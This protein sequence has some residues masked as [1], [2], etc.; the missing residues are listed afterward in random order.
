MF[1]GVLTSLGACIDQIS[2]ELEKLNISDWELTS[3]QATRCSLVATRVRVST[4]DTSHH[5]SWSSIDSLIEQSKI[6]SFAS[7]GARRSFRLLAEAEAAIH[8]V[9]VDDVHFHEVGA[10]D[11]IVDIVGSWVALASLVAKQQVKE[12]ITGPVGLGHGIV[13][14][15]HGTLPLPAPATASLLHGALVQPLDAAGES[16]TPT[17]A[18]LLASMTDRWGPIPSGVLLRNGRG[19]GG[20]DPKH[21][22]N[23]ISGYLLAIEPREIR[24]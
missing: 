3:E 1:L 2:T 4:S 5:R 23:V 16:V 21:Y 24:H 12:V 8:D 7:N 9:D 10:V 14:A 19:A 11:A 18:A 17:G 13:V 6:D 20:R 22:P 15:A